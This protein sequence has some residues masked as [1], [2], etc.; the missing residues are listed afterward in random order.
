VQELG[1]NGATSPANPGLDE[2]QQP[3]EEPPRPN[4]S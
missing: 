3:G 4:F 1:P 2:E